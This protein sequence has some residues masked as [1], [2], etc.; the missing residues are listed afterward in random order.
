MRIAGLKAGATVAAACEALAELFRGSGIDSPQADARILV[1]HALGLSRARLIAEADRELES[2]EIDA[3]A[4]RAVRRSVREPVARIVGTKEFWSLPFAVTP[5]VLVPRPE[6]EIV[7]ELALERTPVTSLRILDIGTGSGAILLAVLSERT[8]MS[9]VGTD[10]SEAALEVARMNAASLRL[11]QR[12]EFVAC[13]IASKVNGTFDLVV[14]NPPYIPAADIA[15]LEPEVRN[16][17]P[18][19]A[20]DGGPDGLDFY[21]AIATDARRLLAPG[22]ALIIE[23]GHGQEAA[24]AA[25]FKQAGLTVPDP[26]RK[27]LAGI[28]RALRAIAP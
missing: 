4:T 1:S 19:R 25:L 11:D 8:A 23:L 20:L 13:D 22:G 26:A 17:D 18:R 6:T 12:C 2:R 10:V 28:S 3:I 9:G 14:S 24:V 21:R 7:V 15:A 16:H 5:D 27:D